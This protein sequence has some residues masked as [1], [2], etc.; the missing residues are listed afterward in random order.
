MEKKKKFLYAFYDLTFL[1]VTYCKIVTNP[2]RY[3]S[4]HVFNP[5]ISE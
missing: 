2:Q 1:F 4:T 3:T 5:Q